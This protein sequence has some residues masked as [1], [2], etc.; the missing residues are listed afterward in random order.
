MGSKLEPPGEIVQHQSWAGEKSPAAPGSFGDLI[1]FE[2][3]E[4][5]P[6]KCKC[7]VTIRDELRNPYGVVHGGVTF[8]LA[9]SAMGLALYDVLLKEEE[10]A[11]NELQI[12]YLKFARFGELTCTAKLIERKSN[13][14]VVE[15]EV[16]NEGRLIARITGTFHIFQNQEQLKEAIS[17]DQKSDS[18]PASATASNIQ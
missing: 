2:F 13:K 11:T 16:E 10:C 8:S 15:A 7:K 1:G 14:G 5:K 3:V 4:R 12:K 17:S 6:G 18:S 9:D